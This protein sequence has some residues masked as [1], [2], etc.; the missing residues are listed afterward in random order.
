MALST[1]E[2]LKNAVIYQIFPRNFS[3]EGTFS[4]VTE[5]LP[6]LNNLGVDIVWF[7]PIHPIGKKNRKGTYGSP[8]SIQDYYKIDPELG[9]KSDFRALIDKAH[10]LG[11]KIMIDIVFNH[12]SRDSL[13]LKEHPEWFYKNKEGLIDTKVSDW[14]DVYDLDFSRIELWEYL[15]SVLE[16]WVDFGVDGF[17]C[18]VAPVLPMEFWIEARKRLNK[19]KEIIWLAESIEPFFI[20]HLRRQGF[21]AASDSE[22]YSAFDLTYDYDSFELLKQV[23]AGRLPLSA[24]L[25]YIS[26]QPSL[27]PDHAVKM[28]FL[29]NHDNYRAADIIQGTERLYNWSLFYMLLPGSTL[30][31]MGQ[32]YRIVKYPDLFEKDTVPWENGKKDFNRFFIKALKTVREI[33]PEINKMNIKEIASG[34]IEISWKKGSN[35]YTAF[36]NLENRYGTAPLN[37]PVKGKDLLTNKDVTYS[38]KIPIPKHPLIIE[39]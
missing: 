30:I 10:N 35:T 37:K 27:F 19:K 22:L 28:R 6:Y 31:Y 5:Q 24:Y 38:N 36:C 20:Q 17:R 12:T 26:I 33:K 8:Y 2:Q 21:Y 39:Q 32:E 23:F 3:I 18:D 16:F 29:E 15:I 34:I 25:S 14:S 4:G 9:S 13:L 7:T 1:P 11:I